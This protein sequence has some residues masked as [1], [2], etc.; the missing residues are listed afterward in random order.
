VFLFVSTAELKAQD[1]FKTDSTFREKLVV[2]TDKSFYVTGEIVWLKIYALND[3]NNLP[4]SI[5]KVAYVELLNGDNKPALQ[6]KLQLN[7]GIGSASLQLPTS[8]NSG[9]YLLRGY[10]A[11]MENFDA[12]GFFSATVSIVN[13]FKTGQ[14]QSEVKSEVGKYDLNFFPES[15]TLIT[16]LENK[17]AFKIT[18]PNGEGVNAT[19]TILDDSNTV[20]AQFSTLKFGIGS[21][22]LTPQAGKH[23]HA[24]I[25]IKNKD[26]TTV[27][28]E[29]RSGMLLHLDDGNA[30][31]LSISIHSQPSSSSS[32]A[33]LLT[34]NGRRTSSPKLIA[35]ENGQASVTIDKTQLSDGITRFTLLNADHQ[36]VASRLYF[37]RPAQRLIDASTDKQVYGKRD[38]ITVSLNGISDVQASLS[39]S[40][41]LIDSLQ[42]AGR[43]SI[44]TY[45]WLGSGLEDPIESP[46]YYFS[47]DKDVAAATDNL[48]LTQR[49]KNS[50]DPGAIV[51]EHP[52]HFP[53]FE[54]HIITG[55]VV[56][57][58]TSEPAANITTYLSVPGQNFRLAVAI[59]SEQG[60]VRFNVPDFVGSEEIVVQTNQTID[61]NYRIDILSPFSD[62]FADFK[63]VRLSVNE[64]LQKQLLQHSIAS[65]VQN[66]YLKDEQNQ[67][68]INTDDTIPFFGYPNRRYFLDD[69]TR[70]TTMEEVLREYVTEVAPRKHADGFHLMVS[71]GKAPSFDKNPLVLADGVPFFNMDTVISF[72]PRKIKSI[73]VVDKKYYYGPLTFYGIVSYASYKGDLDGINLDPNSLVMEY[74]GMQLQRKFYSPVYETDTQ[75][76]NRIPD[77][78]N[79]LF[80]VP[81]IHLN[82]HEQKNLSFYSSDVAGDYVIVL[83]GIT[84]DGKPVTRTITFRVN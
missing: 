37:K 28:P 82:A 84:S 38:K 72:D 15:G 58:K 61:S 22:T 21:L 35:L 42:A 56:N 59:S 62:K 78:R 10:T 34:Q 70:F 4:D 26:F 9:N 7:N 46:E 45:L 23:Y 18:G 19:G 83:E 44:N 68:S 13:P 31:N 51:A 64:Q 8:L 81:V 12:N 79:T 63:A 52:N 39:M 14:F 76:K 25:S 11:W 48:M 43:N 33:F 49:S 73:S 41:Y 75:R 6:A 1:Y 20:V 80:W 50:T 17:L 77:F 16:G 66:T 74:D 54:G 29:Q 24:T 55:K 36:P 30:S 2:L 69:Y 67:F 27:L 53:E 32:N 3:V 47:D 57:K 71:D 40:V 65:Q 5:S 60:I